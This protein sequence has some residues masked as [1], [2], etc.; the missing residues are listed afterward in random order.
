MDY[1]VELWVGQIAHPKR[2]DNY[3]GA[4]GSMTTLTGDGPRIS[5]GTHRV[6]C[7]ALHLSIEYSAPDPECGPMKADP[8]GLTRRSCST[9]HVFILALAV[10]VWSASVRFRPGFDGVCFSLTHYDGISGRNDHTPPI[11]IP[12][13]CQESAQTLR[14]SQFKSVGLIQRAGLW[15]Q[16]SVGTVPTTPYASPS[17]R[18]K[19][20]RCHK[21]RRK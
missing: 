12:F 7:S 17:A 1:S 9:G 2:R 16:S 21:P 20:Y 15:S 19:P 3:A 8:I 6:R 11:I 4:E 14:F 5:R 18:A 13:L 10:P